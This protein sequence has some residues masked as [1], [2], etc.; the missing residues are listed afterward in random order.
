MR[1]MKNFLAVGCICLLLTMSACTSAQIVNTI[2]VSIQLISSILP[3]IS[4][5]T[6]MTTDQNAM[7]L[8]YLQ[9]SDTALDQVNTILQQ[10][11]SKAVIAVKITAALSGVVAATP[12]PNGT[13]CKRRFYYT[14]TSG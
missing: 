4:A 3:I 11:G 12:K 8:T 5:N 13:P 9:E 1:V 2:E 10:G 6:G 14:A 7:V